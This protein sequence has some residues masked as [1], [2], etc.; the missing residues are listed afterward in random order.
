MT[1]LHRLAARVSEYGLYAL[2]LLQPATGLAQ[3]VLRGRSFGLLAWSIPPLSSVHLGYARLFEGFHV[4]GA[5]CLIALVSLHA[6]A[7]LFHHFV[8]H[9]HVLESMAPFLGRKPLC[10]DCQRRVRAGA[11]GLD[12]MG[13]G[14]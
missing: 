12:Q 1:R 14:E 7:A 13:T 10:L 6:A 9:D 11:R 5:W 3:T 2:L 4:V 8:R